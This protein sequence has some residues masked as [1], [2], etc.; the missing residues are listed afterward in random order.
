MACGQAAGVGAGENVDIVV[1]AAHG[2]GH[3]PCLQTVAATAY[4]GTFDIIGFNE[5]CREFSVGDPSRPD[6]M[7]EHMVCR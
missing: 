6:C 2:A 1:N 7:A 3:S 5:A 4:T